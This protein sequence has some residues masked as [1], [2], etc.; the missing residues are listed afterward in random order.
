MKPEQITFIGEHLL[1]GY[2]GYF[3]VVLS[4]GAVLMSFIAYTLYSRK[5][6]QLPSWK[7]I[8]RISFSLH[9][10]S[11]VGI[12]STLFYLIHAHYFE[13]SYVW[14]HSSK[15]LA[16]EYM[17][18]CFWE[19]QEGSFLLWTFWH[20]VLGTV[21]IFKAKDWE[22]PV[23]SVVCLAQLMLT[24]MLLGIDKV[25]LYFAIVDLPLKL[26]SNPF[27]LLRVANPNLPFARMPNYLQALTDGR[28]LN[29]TLQNYWMVIHPPVLFLG[30]ASTLI[31]FAY[32]L[33]GI[34]TKQF[35]EW[36]VKALPWTAFA[37]L[38][39]G[40]GVLMGGAWA[41]EALSF[42]GFWAWDPVENASLV[43]W[44]VLIAAMHCMIIYK[45]RKTSLRI[46]I[47]LVFISF[48][49]ILYSTFL[50]R[51]GILGDTSV[52]SFTDLGLSGQLM[53]FLF[54]FI[55]IVVYLLI[56]NWKKIPSSRDDDKI[57]SRE[58]WM[59]IG[60][61]L[62]SL[63]A[64]HIISITSIPVFNSLF[65]LSNEYFHTSFKT[66]FAKPAD[67]IGTYHALQ[68]PFAMLIALLAG[69][70]QYLKFIN[71]APKLFWKKMAI[72]GGISLAFAGTMYYFQPM[73]DYRYLILLF[74]SCFAIVGNADIWISKLKGS[75]WKISGAATAHIGF[76]MILLGAL[77]ANANKQTISLNTEGFDVVKME[78]AREQY[79][80]KTLFIGM[81]AKMLDYQVEYLGDSSDGKHVYFKVNYKR[82][83]SAT[84]NVKE[85]FNLY[86]Y[87]IYNE[88]QGK[89][90]APS[91]DTKHYWSKDVFTHI[92]SAPQKEDADYL[93]TYDTVYNVRIKAG[94]TLLIDSLKIHA[95]DIKSFQ[96][97]SIEVP[98]KDYSVAAQL[99]LTFSLLE[100]KKEVS[101]KPFYVIKGKEVISEFVEAA[102]AG[103]KVAFN[104]INLEDK[105][106]SLT[107][108][109][110]KPAP[111]RFITLKAITFPL[112]N[113]L[114]MGAVIMAVGFVLTIRKRVKKN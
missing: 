7:T 42:G 49:L 92:T 93:P 56:R 62:L 72:S 73:Q 5:G 81:P 85:D 82:T 96:N 67:P 75:R 33:A 110:G 88:K 27:T 46:S 103:I 77:I 60:S 34:R 87:V 17:I 25:D 83:D 102:D 36:V 70:G 99:P 79:E 57:Y 58:F 106:F 111:P 24:S 14:T 63:A 105:S 98:V 76:G 69:F 64:L 97:G 61:L 11:V 9:F 59:F 44:L 100:L 21:L 50:T 41:Y 104:T 65:K 20:C 94:E 31:P 22:G 114:W 112:I 68:V 2:L 39:L 18:A 45:A 10:V 51:S 86:P 53:L 84:G 30:F 55:G 19:G 91:P 109:R 101:L 108:Y 52:H 29:V 8:G 3:F 40:V 4:F 48:L 107:I 23:M 80:N 28:G 95:G 15:D 12:F 89:Y 35:G 13:Y 71:T 6:E 54:L 32:A 66:N 90:E 1:P 74:C 47:L 78:N 43:P 26:G 113:L 16:P 38:T 37:G